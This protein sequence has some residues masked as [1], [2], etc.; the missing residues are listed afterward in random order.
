MVNSNK[1]IQEA[2][3]EYYAD[4]KEIYLKGGIAYKIA[5]G[6]GEVPAHQLRKIL[7]Q[8]KQARLLLEKSDKSKWDEVLIEARNLIYYIVPLT[9][10]NFSRFPKNLKELNEFVLNNIN[11]KTITS[12]ED[13]VVLDQLFTSIIAYHKAMIEERKMQKW[14]IEFTK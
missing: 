6:M 7:S 1:N 5:N 10:Y 12:Y 8:I 4:K 13:I 2:L 11:E 14:L 9:A 3:S